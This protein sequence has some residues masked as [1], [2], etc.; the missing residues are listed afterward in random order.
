MARRKVYVNVFPKAKKKGRA[1]CRSTSTLI[2]E[3]MGLKSK[4]RYW[5]AARKGGS[6]A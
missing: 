1:Q 4:K 3:T 6:R 2:K 5:L